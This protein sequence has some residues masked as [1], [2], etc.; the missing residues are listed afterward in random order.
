LHKD[1]NLRYAIDINKNLFP[2]VRNLFPDVECFTEWTRIADATDIDILV[3]SLPTE[4]HYRCLRDFENNLNIKIYFIEKPLF[5]TQDEYHAISDNMRDKIIVNYI[6]RFDPAFTLLKHKIKK[7]V[8][9]M[10]LKV[11]CKYTKGLKNNGIHCIDL[12][13]YLFCNPAILE[14]KVLDRIIDYQEKDPTFDLF[15]KMKTKDAIFPV[16]FIGLNE[17]NYSIFEME[18]LF[19]NKRVELDDSAIKVSEVIKSKEYAGYKILDE[20]AAHITTNMRYIMLNAYNGIKKTLRNNIKEISSF[21]D[22]IQNQD[23]INSVNKEI[24]YA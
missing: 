21:Q 10:P 16:Y 14:V 3:I 8:Y 7:N 20:N 15:I 2:K 4:M 1:F 24:D 11:I 23:F 9:R 6:R 5:S 22:E 12:I 17:N 13:N 18:L 19:E